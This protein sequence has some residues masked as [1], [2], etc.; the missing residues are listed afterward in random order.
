MTWPNKI[1]YSRI[2][3]IPVFIIAV[4]QI[5]EYPFFKFVALGIFAAIA[6]GDALDGYVARRLHLETIEGKFIDPMADKLV[7]TSA[8]I[9]L[10]LPLWGS[11]TPPLR[12]EIAIIIIARD[13]LICLMVIIAY[14]A[15][16]MKVFE[17]SRLGRWTTF[18]QM[19]MI[20]TAMA[21]TV[22]P[23]ILR[24]AAIPLS[25]VTAVLTIASGIQYFYGR[26]RHS[27]FSHQS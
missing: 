14:I 21:G 16:I 26:A 3:L 12:L 22:S 27:L 25:Y 11:A 5:R 15:N 17:P 9:L 8:C 24:F 1:T 13:L 20:S 19:V 2:L 7:M 6:I 23:L 4:L 10:A 18:T